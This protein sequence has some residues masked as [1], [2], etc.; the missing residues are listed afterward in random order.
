MRCR[1]TCLTRIGARTPN[2]VPMRPVIVPLMGLPLV[3]MTV[4]WPAHTKLFV[5][6]TTATP[7]LARHRSCGKSLVAHFDATDIAG[8]SGPPS[9]L[10]SSS[11][12]ARAL[13]MPS[14]G[15]T[16]LDRLPLQQ[17]VRDDAARGGRTHVH[18]G[19]EPCP[20]V[21]AL[22][23]VRVIPLVDGDAK[24]VRQAAHQNGDRE[25]TPQQ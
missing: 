12:Q 9:G 21:I 7:S 24:R 1:R 20:V 5:R 15:T 18:G 16:R 22:R 14:H 13:E 11:H 4:S 25:R 3:P 19:H 2:S 6:G 10:R 17:H 23:R 8:I